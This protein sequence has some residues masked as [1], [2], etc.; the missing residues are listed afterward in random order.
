MPAG[1]GLGVPYKTLLSPLEVMKGAVNSTYLGNL[2]EEDLK[3]T[4][5]RTVQIT[6]AQDVMIGHIIQDDNFGY[7][8]AKAQYIRHMIEMG[9]T[10]YLEKGLLPEERVGYFGDMLRAARMLREDAARE[11][12]RENMAE[13]IKTHD[14]ALDVARGTGDWALVAQRLRRYMDALESCEAESQ[15][16]ILRGVFAESASTRTAVHS[17]NR[18]LESPNRPPKAGIE[19]WED[20]WPEIATQWE[21]WYNEY[22]GV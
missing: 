8:G 20:W 7:E 4:V 17:F 2:S 5:T 3:D 21:T 19:G 14:R 16:R 10:Y 11:K 22:G 12:T 15:R 6:R 9:L 13:D 1:S 18:W